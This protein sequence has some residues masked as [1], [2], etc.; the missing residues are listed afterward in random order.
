M[1]NH[2][3]KIVTDSSA[4]LL[5]MDGVEFASVPLKVIVGEREFADDATVDME[6]LFH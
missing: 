2:A 5:A 3:V 6:E 4:N 1:N